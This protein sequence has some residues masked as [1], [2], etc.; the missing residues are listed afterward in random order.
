MI[1]IFEPS[2]RDSYYNAPESDIALR[3]YKLKELGTQNI[4]ELKSRPEMMA[5]ATGRKPFISMLMMTYTPAFS[6]PCLPT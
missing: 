4:S 6:L 3:Y 1:I 5:E 2:F